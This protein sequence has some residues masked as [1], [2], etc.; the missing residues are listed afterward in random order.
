M[1]KKEKEK[2]KEKE[3]VENYGPLRFLM[4]GKSER[5]RLSGET[6]EAK[7]LFAEDAELKKIEELLLHV[8]GEL[9][10]ADGRERL[11]NLMLKWAKY[12]RKARR[13]NAKLVRDCC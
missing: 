8:E 12:N 7:E 3:A 2:E 9:I 6:A 5:V 10:D 11:L 4:H 1:S 13:K